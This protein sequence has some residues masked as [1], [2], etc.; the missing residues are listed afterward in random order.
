MAIQPV[1]QK[2][3]TIIEPNT[4]EK[5][6]IKIEPPQQIYEQEKK[7]IRKKQLIWYIWLVLQ[8]ILTFRFLLKL[9]GAN[10]SSLFSIIITILSTPFTIIFSGLFQ[11][12]NLPNTNVAIEWSTLFAM[13]VFGIIAWLVTYF[14]RLKKPL[15]P[16]EADK[17]VDLPMP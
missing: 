9:F 10:P 17:K 12:T 5:P 1:T 6:V 3:K 16:E 11:P 2:E 8:V 7:I 14:F 13:L 15:D 4:G